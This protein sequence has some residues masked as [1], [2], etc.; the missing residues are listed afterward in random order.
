M[1]HV[2]K[3]KKKKINNAGLLIHHVPQIDAMY[4]TICFRYFKYAHYWCILAVEHFRLHDYCGTTNGWNLC[5]F[6]WFMCR[7]RYASY[8][9]GKIYKFATGPK[10][11]DLSLNVQGAFLS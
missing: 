3:L 8:G 4:Q 5:R 11:Q 9:R 1:K 10:P 7:R 6:C 2:N